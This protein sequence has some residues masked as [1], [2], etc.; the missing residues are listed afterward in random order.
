M[1][2]AYEEG[3]SETR[4][5]VISLTSVAATDA[6]VPPRGAALFKGPIEETA[7]D[8]NGAAA[9]ASFDARTLSTLL[10]EAFAPVPQPTPE[11]APSEAPRSAALFKGPIEET[12]G[13]PSVATTPAS[14]DARALSTLLH[15]VFAPAPQPTPEPVPSKAP[16]K[17]PEIA[18]PPVSKP[19]PEPAPA[20]EK[21]PA[22]KPDS[23]WP[24]RLV[25]TSLGLGVAAVVGWTPVMR[26][27]ELTSAEAVVNARLVTLRSPIEG[28]IRAFDISPEVGA[29]TDK[30]HLVLRITNPRADRARLDD[31]QRMIAQVDGER[32]AIAARLARL[33]ELQAKVAEQA[34]SFQRGRIRELEARVQEA[35]SALA[36]VT[37]SRNEAGTAAQRAGALAQS[38]TGT[39]VA[40]EKAQRDLT[41]ATETENSL[42]HRLAG[43]EIELEAARHGSFIGDSYN[44]RPSSMQQSDE[45]SVRIVDLEAELRTRD[46][47]LL[48]LNE[49]LR[50]ET[51][52]YAEVSQ[53]EIVSPVTGSVWE[54]LVSPGEE[55][56]RGQDLV[57]M[58]D[59]S[60]VVVTA[61]VTETVYNRLRVGD[62]ARL[63]LS[64]EAVDHLGTVVRLSG[65]AAPPDNLAILPSSLVSAAYRVHVTIPDLAGSGCAVGRTGK[66]VFQTPVNGGAARAGSPDA[67][68]AP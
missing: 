31:L 40:L 27:L 30:G 2:P 1:P 45:L 28:E 63:R 61:S 46:E 60:G 11:P 58:L 23:P 18:A 16:H 54:M 53:A 59:C 36:A 66:V 12:A 55:V 19:A 15:E 25:K 6:P 26:M 4:A 29:R 9:P 64:G 38:G 42:K 41:V 33:N 68:K 32:P 21:A 56:R 10:H 14:F 47:R 5:P 17:A 13:D 44:D 65:L 8:S 62:K 50:L 35:T 3:P 20:P 24:R 67:R 34:R 7:R 37:A 49:Q 48:R 57:R 52:R 43:I 51:A 22:R 39:K